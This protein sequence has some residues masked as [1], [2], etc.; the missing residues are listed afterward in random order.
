MTETMM[1]PHNFSSASLAAARETRSP[2]LWRRLFTAILAGRQRKADACIADY[3]KRA[4]EPR[5]RQAGAR[6]LLGGCD[7]REV[8]KRQ[9][10]PD[11]HPPYDQGAL[12]VVASA[13]L[14]FYVVAAIHELMTSGN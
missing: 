14:A 7:L 3:R 1:T 2:P 10:E 4:G 5:W 11:A 12:V 9:I 8:E 6:S 13:W